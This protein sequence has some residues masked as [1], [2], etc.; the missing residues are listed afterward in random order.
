MTNQAKTLVSIAIALP[1][2]S[3]T[4]CGVNTSEN[5]ANTAD[6]K[7]AGQ[8][9]NTNKPVK[10]TL[11]SYAVT[12]KA[13]QQIIPKFAEKWKAQTGQTVEFDQSYG[14]SGSQTRAVIDGL[15]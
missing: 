1:I 11:V 2:I 7:T 9:V 12:Q 15:E 4:S 13:Y 14:G 10:L 3:L 8:P 5:V 6:T